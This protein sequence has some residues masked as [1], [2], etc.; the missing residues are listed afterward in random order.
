MSVNFRKFSYSLLLL[1]GRL[2]FYNSKSKVLYYH[3]IY[4]DDQDPDTEMATK[5]SLFRNHV[6]IIRSAG[7]EIV[8][9]ITRPNRQVM[10]T[11]DDGFSGIYKNKELFESENITATI[12]MI[13]AAIGKS[14]YLTADQIAEMI[15][16]G[17]RIQS[18]THGHRDMTTLTAAELHEDLRISKQIM[19]KVVPDVTE[20][21]FPYGRFSKP[22]L[23][24]AM[25][26]GYEHL[27]CSIPGNCTNSAN[28]GL[29]YRNLVQ[30]ASP[31]DL[32]NILFG[33]MAIFKNR[34]TAQHYDRK[35][36]R[37]S[38]TSV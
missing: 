29:V 11:F 9:V 23:R 7:F 16:L 37:L 5:L 32:K 10:L 6:R 14:H 21:C 22:V 25:A 38:A 24:I 17:F 26:S 12:F 33:G 15:R 31:T 28:R 4:A 18:H 27:Y 13:T 30:W 35:P 1:I 3:D 19:E 8:P 36:I 34:Y 2:V 20:L